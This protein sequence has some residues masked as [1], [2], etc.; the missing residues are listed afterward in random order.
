MPSRPV[1][2]VSRLRERVSYYS[3]AT[4]RAD[5][6][7]SLAQVFE[8][9]APAGHIKVDVLIRALTNDGTDKLTEEQ[10]Q[11]LVSQLEPDRNG[12]INYSEY[13]NMMMSD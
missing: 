2:G 3:K 8:G 9:A 10:A 1:T 6:R 13:V 11:D 12:L 4:L 5:A 7:P